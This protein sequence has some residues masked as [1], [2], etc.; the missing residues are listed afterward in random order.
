MKNTS[1]GVSGDATSAREAKRIFKSI[2]GFM[3]APEPKFIIVRTEDSEYYLTFNRGITIE[4]FLGY[5]ADEFNDM[6]NR[7]SEFKEELRK[8]GAAIEK[9]GCEVAAIAVKIGAISKKL[10]TLQNKNQKIN[11][12]ATGL[13]NS[14][15]DPAKDLWI[16]KMEAGEQISLLEKRIGSN[17]KAAEILRT[18]IMQLKVQNFQLPNGL[19]GVL[20]DLKKRM[21]GSVASAIWY[22]GR[23]DNFRK[24]NAAMF[25]QDVTRIG[26]VQLREQKKRFE[27]DITW[28]AGQMDDFKWQ[29][30]TQILT[31]IR[32]AASLIECVHS[33]REK[34]GNLMCWLRDVGASSGKTKGQLAAVKRENQANEAQIAALMSQ[35]KTI[36]FELK[37]T[38]TEL[39][40]AK[41]MFNSTHK[42]L[43][44][45]EQALNEMRREAAT[46]EGNL[47]SKYAEIAQKLAEIG[48]LTYDSALE[49]ELLFQQSSKFSLAKQE[50]RRAEWNVEE[51]CA[52]V[53]RLTRW[54]KGAKKQQSAKKWNRA[55]IIKRLKS[56]IQQYTK[57]FDANYEIYTKFLDGEYQRVGALHWKAEISQRRVGAL[58]RLVSSIQAKKDELLK[59][60]QLKL[61]TADEELRE[62][63]AQL[64]TWNEQLKAAR[65]AAVHAHGKY[66]AASNRNYQQSI[67]NTRN[68]WSMALE[69]WEALLDKRQY[70]QKFTDDFIERDESPENVVE[71]LKGELL[72]ARWNLVKKTQ[73]R[74]MICDDWYE[75]KKQKMATLAN[76]NAATVELETMRTKAAQLGEQLEEKKQRIERYGW[77]LRSLIGTLREEIFDETEGTLLGELK[78]LHTMAANLPPGMAI[79]LCIGRLDTAI[80]NIRGMEN[81]LDVL[82]DK[83]I[84]APERRRAEFEANLET[85]GA[86]A[87]TGAQHFNESHD[88]MLE[89]FCKIGA[90]IDT[91]YADRPAT[92]DEF[93]GVINLVIDASLGHLSRDGDI[94]AYKD[95]FGIDA[96]VNQYSHSI[97][98]TL[99]VNVRE[100]YLRYECFNRLGELMLTTKNLAIE[101]VKNQIAAKV[102][103]A[104]KNYNYG[105]D[106]C[107]VPTQLATNFIEACGGQRAFFARM[108]A[109]EVDR[110][111]KLVEPIRATIAGLGEAMDAAILVMG[112]CTEFVEVESTDDFVVQAKFQLMQT[113]DAPLRTLARAMFANLGNGTRGKIGEIFACINLKCNL[114][115]RGSDFDGFV[116]RLNLGG[117]SH[118]FNETTWAEIN[119]IAERRYDESF[120]NFFT[121]NIKT[122]LLKIN[123]F[124]LRDVQ[125]SGDVDSSDKIVYWWEMQL[126]DEEMVAFFYKIQHCIEN[127]DCG[128]GIFHVALDEFFRQLIFIA[129]DRVDVPKRAA[130]LDLLH[131]FDTHNDGT[132]R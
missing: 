4:G 118:F 15:S 10:K 38:K 123:G 22:I 36:K 113:F 59:S 79:Y 66:R 45:T 89:K 46:L 35:L 126:P 100:G 65:K 13:Q 107:E 51:L 33:L 2:E 132:P 63:E 64:A 119:S 80:A 1:D 52:Q 84:T 95:K 82:E 31:Q 81:S 88:W 27:A 61:D 56:L 90:G 87:A 102:L 62:I 72:A 43:I 71:R 70:L 74:D 106:D 101:N 77:A 28:I 94:G 68:R 127:G 105:D 129:C 112:G 124:M 9:N 83:I 73:N 69:K 115:A 117:G 14:L 55:G 12:G 40:L 39:Q 18:K 108:L 30:S 8:A 111:A 17:E 44:G 3:F 93:I 49:R 98:T 104:I 85:I 7:I 110:V 54:L 121:G 16:K 120:T 34:M 103:D 25:G 47:G 130:Y 29:N 92:V 53:V 76:L 60:E 19:D 48:K 37:D 109:V 20:F 41:G 24:Q 50:A 67:G 21:R 97:K 125:L 11:A 26:L 114:L 86:S 78:N 96:L 23:L 57:K 58:E 91:D 5:V 32:T 6:C 75:L 116:K 99:E 122:L 131:K 42:R 128:S